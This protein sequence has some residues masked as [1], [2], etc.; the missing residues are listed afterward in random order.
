M[1]RT[2]FLPPASALLALS[3]PTLALTQETTQAAP[4]DASPE[5]ETVSATSAPTPAGPEDW[6]K[7]ERLGAT[8]LSPDGRWLAYE[9]RRVDGSFD[10]HLRVLATDSTEV[11]ENGS[12][13]RF[14][15]TG[16]GWPT[17]SA[18]RR[19]SG[20]S[21]RNRRSPWSRASVYST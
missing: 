3:L 11:F 18:T 21:W 15:R 8:T 12:R 13:P 9:V 17:G 4:Q 14:R 20:R 1:I 10:L 5:T 7:W 16:P 19:P 2:M 6:E